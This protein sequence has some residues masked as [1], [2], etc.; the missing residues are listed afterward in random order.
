MLIQVVPELA[1]GR[2]GVSDHATQLAGHLRDEF[3]IESAFVSLSGKESASMPFP[4]V[5]CAAPGLLENC[6]ALSQGRRAA[7]LVH[8]SGYGYSPDG[9]P[10]LL[11]D[12][13]EQVRAD[14]RFRTSVYFHEL[15]AWGPPWRSAFW[16]SRRQQRALRKLAANCDLVVTNTTRHLEWLQR[17]TRIP[18]GVRMELIPV[19]S[20]VGEAQEPVPFAR[21]NAVMAVFGLAGTRMRAYQKIAASGD[22]VRTLGIEEIH[23]IGPECDHPS[24]L[25]GLP[26]KRV[27]LLPVEEIPAV[28]STVRFGFVSHPMYCL[29]KS[30]VLAS[31]CAQGVVPVLAEGFAGVADGLRD[32]V[33]VVS[34]QTAQAARKTGLENCAHAAW[35]WYMTHSV[36]VHAER[37]A[38]WMAEA[39]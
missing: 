7:L 13:L 39:Q 6:L 18:D 37:F 9:A 23:D 5:E 1:P 2:S 28:F 34:A 10:T 35:N 12:A 21:R 29:G 22:L 25:K 26:V 19:L 33:H 15:Y 24:R 36:R 38:R 32:G 14:G 30:G 31:Y 16:Y 11:A 8:V 20:T 3:G 27:G 4:S 17:E